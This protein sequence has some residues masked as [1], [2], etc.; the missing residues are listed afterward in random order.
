[1]IHES[2]KDGPG[3]MTSRLFETSNHDPYAEKRASVAER[4]MLSRNFVHGTEDSVDTV[5]GVTKEVIRKPLV[6]R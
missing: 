4:S 2:I 6:Y 1:M 5:P 3:D